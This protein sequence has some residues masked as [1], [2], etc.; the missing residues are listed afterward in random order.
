MLWKIIGW[1]NCSKRPGKK[2][3]KT[4]TPIKRNPETLFFN[5]FAPKLRVGEKNCAVELNYTL[6]NEHRS[7]Q[8]F[9]MPLCYAKCLNIL[10]SP[11]ETLLY[12]LTQKKKS[13]TTQQWNLFEVS[14]VPVM[15]ST[16]NRFYTSFAEKG[17]GSFC[18]TLKETDYYSGCSRLTISFQT[19]EEKKSEVRQGSAQQGTRGSIVRSRLRKVGVWGKHPPAETTANERRG[20]S[21]HSSRGSACTRLPSLQLLASLLSMSIRSGNFFLYDPPC[22]M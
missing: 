2:K 5:P 1:M 18:S 22:F 16:I 13:K 7:H 17:R 10:R 4:T 8:P 14:K 20:R 12:W 11:S 19:V 6:T 3:K 21:W 9:K 15:Q